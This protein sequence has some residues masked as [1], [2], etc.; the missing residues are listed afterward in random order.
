MQEEEGEGEEEVQ[1]Q[2][3]GSTA[4]PPRSQPVSITSDKSSPRQLPPDTL[5]LTAEDDKNQL[6]QPSIYLDSSQHHKIIFDA[7]ETVVVE[8][9]QY[10]V[11]PLEERVEQQ[12]QSEEAD[13]PEREK[14][15]DSSIREKTDESSTS[16]DLSDKPQPW[17]LVGDRYAPIRIE[18]VSTYHIVC[19]LW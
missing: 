14:K 7:S 3:Q 19:M 10:D 18:Q 4:S 17:E 6:K 16:S 1:M 5:E 15:D 11:C 2:I 9:D 12:A 8:A 13:S